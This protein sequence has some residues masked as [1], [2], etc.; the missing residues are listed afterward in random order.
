MKTIFSVSFFCIL[1]CASA[2]SQEAQKLDEFERIT[3]DD[4][5]ARM[6]NTI[7]EA[8]N[9][10]S[11]TIYILVYEGKEI[12]YNSRKKKDELA[13]PTFGSAKAKIDSMKIYLAKFGVEN[14]SFIE[15]G[16]RETWIVE[17]W[18]A[19]KGA[20][21]PKPTPTVTKMKHRKGK[22]IGFCTWCC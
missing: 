15:A 19:P 3:C 20:S 17:I 21:P 5:L 2:F 18:L 12:K 7:N 4:Y 1:F 11:S 16:F 8:R 10:P 14:F 13:L 9:N 6:D 22:A